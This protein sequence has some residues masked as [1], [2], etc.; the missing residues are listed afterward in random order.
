MPTSVWKL[1]QLVASPLDQRT[2]AGWLGDVS[3]ALIDYFRAVEHWVKQDAQVASAVET[4]RLAFTIHNDGSIGYLQ[5]LTNDAM[6]H[7]APCAVVID[8]SLSSAAGPFTT[9]CSC[10]KS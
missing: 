7:R 4:V 3:N 9:R 1:K 5:V 6:L 2:I 8:L 10:R